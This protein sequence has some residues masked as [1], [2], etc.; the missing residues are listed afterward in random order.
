MCIN[1]LRRLVGI[2]VSIAANGR[3]PPINGNHTITINQRLFQL[4]RQNL[5]DILY[6]KLL[7]RH[8]LPLFTADAAGHCPIKPTLFHPAISLVCKHSFL[9][10][11][12]LKSTSYLVIRATVSHHG[13][14]N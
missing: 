11:G 13:Q 3:D 9:V 12:D 5:T 1:N 7:Y 6:Y 8:D 10:Q 4:A 14:L 2:K